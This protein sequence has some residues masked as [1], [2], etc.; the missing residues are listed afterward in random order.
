MTSL[1]SEEAPQ[2]FLPPRLGLARPSLHH[3]PRLYPSQYTWRKHGQLDRSWSRSE[4]KKGTAWQAEL[5]RHPRLLVIGEVGSGKTSLLRYLHLQDVPYAEDGLPVRR[6]FYL[7]LRRGALPPP[8]ESLES[9]LAGEAGTQAGVKVLLERGEVQVLLDD[10]DAVGASAVPW[11]REV[12]DWYP[13]SQWLVVSRR[14][15][16]ESLSGFEVL[17]LLPWNGRLVEQWVAAQGWAGKVV[18]RSALREALRTVPDLA[19]TPLLVRLL[20]D[21]VGRGLELPRRCLEIYDSYAR[22]LLSRCS[23]RGGVSALLEVDLSLEL[24]GPLALQADGGGK[25]QRGM[26]VELIA[27]RMAQIGLKIHAATAVLDEVGVGSGLLAVVGEEEVC[28]PSLGLRCYLG[29]RERTHHP[30]GKGPSAAARGLRRGISREELLWVSMAADPGPSLRALLGARDDIF[31]RRL[32]EAARQ[33]GAA[34]YVP[35][36]YRQ[37]VRV[38]LLRLFW[39]G[40][41][42]E[43]QQQAL[44]GLCWMADQEIMGHLVSAVR[45][46]LALIRTRAA[47][48]LARMRGPETIPSLQEAL[49]DPAWKVRVHAAEGLGRLGDRGQWRGL[50]VALD[51]PH[52]QVRIS[53]ADALGWLG[54]EA[55]AP[56]LRAALLEGYCS[57]QYHTAALFGRLGMTG[58]AEFPQKAA[59]DQD[60]AL[61]IRLA[62]ALLRLG[63]ETS[64]DLLYEVLHG[65]E[66]RAR[67][68]V[69]AVLAKEGVAEA[70]DV[71][72]SGCESGDA[73]LRYRAALGASFVPFVCSIEYPPDERQHLQPLSGHLETLLR[74]PSWKVRGVAAVALGSMGPLAMGRPIAALLEDP[75][76]FVSTNAA[77]ALGMA[78]DGKAAGALLAVME[79]EGRPETT[80][81]FAG[82]ALGTLGVHTALEPLS[83]ALRTGGVLL[84]V[85]AARALGD[86]G[87]ATHLEL[88]LRRATED[89][90]PLVRNAAFA[91]ACCLCEREEIELTQEALNCL[92]A[93]RRRAVVDAVTLMQRY[94]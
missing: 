80:R 26:A 79:D 24:L 3:A 13:R 82:R 62:E 10:L 16:K 12:V 71:L 90:E 92:P 19:L 4:D 44:A 73:G 35:V 18:S 89:E 15:L 42:E 50:A 20:A 66:V 60:L 86:L 87:E 5:N 49:G 25:L 72:R 46:P 30:E 29:A 14:D 76:H 85:N 37:Q 27:A 65:Q 1:V 52:W 8:G 48:A 74:D 59:D 34:R 64:Y 83:Q 2:I 57:P 93:F 69:A 81:A 91:A 55:A 17:H 56:R 61:R 78:S 68:A 84:R 75:N 33:I 9:R 58:E 43:Q 22:L 47:E 53:A 54:V 36:E 41:Y 94:Y 39:Q 21:L 70:L 77:V 31:H 7:S 63:T 23:Y 6:R 40:V 45:N 32:L 38:R 28:F 67:L 88:L 11:L 51:D